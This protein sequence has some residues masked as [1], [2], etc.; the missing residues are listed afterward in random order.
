MALDPNATMLANLINPW[1][2]ADMIDKKLVDYMNNR[3][4]SCR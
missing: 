3:H 1:V 2:L 4:Y